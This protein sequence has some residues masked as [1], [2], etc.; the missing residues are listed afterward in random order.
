MYYAFTVD[1][2]LPPELGPNGFE[3]PRG[4]LYAFN[5]REERRRFIGSTRHAVIASKREV[6]W[7]LG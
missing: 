1:H 3:R 6:K 5:T 7:L 2:T 4:K